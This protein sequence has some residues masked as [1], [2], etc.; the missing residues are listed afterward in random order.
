MNVY[1][2]LLQVVYE[3]KYDLLQVVY[4]DK[5]LLGDSNMYF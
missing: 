4:E 1:Y 2:D 3:E 5:T